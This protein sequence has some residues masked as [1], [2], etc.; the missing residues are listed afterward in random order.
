LES[1]QRAAPLQQQG[2]AFEGWSLQVAV[3]FPKR[4]QERPV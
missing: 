3:A 2:N 4:L 1:L